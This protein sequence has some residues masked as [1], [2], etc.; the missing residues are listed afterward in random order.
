MASTDHAAARGREARRPRDI[1]KRGWRDVAW[2]VKDEVTNDNVSIVAGGVAFYIFLAIFPA[3]A[4]ALAIYGIYADPAQAAQQIESIAQFLPSQVQD[5]LKTQLGR[6]A[7][8]SQGALGVGALIGVLLSLWS[9]AKG[10]KALMTALN[11]VYDEE[12]TRGFFKL[13]AMALGLT[14]GVIVFG[15][16]ALIL[17]AAIPALL[18]NLGLGEVVKWIVSLARWPI[19]FLVVMTIIAVLYRYAPDRDRPQWQW[20]TPG[21]VIATVLWLIASI[22]FSVYVSYSGS[23][24]ATYGSLAAVVILLFWLYLSA[25]VVMVGAEWNAEME[26]QTRKD[27][28][29]GKPASMGQRGAHAADTLGEER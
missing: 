26:R 22:A 9:A 24:N 14:L 27:T 6:I 17:I 21:A 5:I 13:N 19:L 29:V 1:P 4:A 16:V 20:N 3:L 11:I 18:G 23:Y 10:M 8:S 25:Y 28:T 7:Q 12:D 15:L 2:R